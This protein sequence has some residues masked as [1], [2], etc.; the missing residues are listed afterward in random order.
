MNPVLVALMSTSLLTIAAIALLTRAIVVSNLSIM[1]YNHLRPY[2]I[3]G[4]LMAAIPVQ[5][6]RFIFYC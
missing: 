5:I 6:A 3:R 2:L 1:N 4:S